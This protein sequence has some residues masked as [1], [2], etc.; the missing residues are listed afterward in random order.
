MFEGP[1]RKTF[2]HVSSGLLRK[3]CPTLPAPL[4]SIGASSGGRTGTSSKLPGL[5]I[6]RAGEAFTM[7][8]GMHVSALKLATSCLASHSDEAKKTV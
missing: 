3:L 5:A 6:R 4:I 2:G 1:L 8:P 7:R